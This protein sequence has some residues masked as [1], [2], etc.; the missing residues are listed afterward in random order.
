MERPICNEVASDEF[1]PLVD[2]I[3]YHPPI[4][5]NIYME[6]H[7]TKCDSVTALLPLGNESSENPSFNLSKCA[8]MSFFTAKYNEHLL[9][10]NIVNLNTETRKWLTTDNVKRYLFFMKFICI[11]YKNDFTHFIRILI[12]YLIWNTILVLF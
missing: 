3:H 6:T 12:E 1:F 9:I 5:I 7:S 10:W 4:F 8:N 11:Y 2:N